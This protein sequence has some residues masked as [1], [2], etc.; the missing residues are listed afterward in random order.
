MQVPGLGWVKVIRSTGYPQSTIYLALLL[1]EN[2]NPSYSYSWV[3]LSS[4]GHS[5]L[6]SS[7]FI[8]RTPPWVLYIPFQSASFTARQRRL[9]RPIN[10]PIRWR[11][12]CAWMSLVIQT[13]LATP[14]WQNENTITRDRLRQRN[15]TRSRTI[16]SH[17]LI[18]LCYPFPS[19]VHRQTRTV[20]E[21]HQPQDRPRWFKQAQLIFQRHNHDYK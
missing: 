4:Q 16:W 2:L 3:W 18:T 19:K 20:F 21:E 14:C 17:K 12:S 9:A 11:T 15:Y 7:F 5:A 10:R 1:K 6:I 8:I 13:T